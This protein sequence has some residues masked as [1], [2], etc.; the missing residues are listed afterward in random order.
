[1]ESMNLSRAIHHETLKPDKAE[2][3]IEAEVAYLQ[4][5]PA[6]ETEKLY[7]M[8]YDTEGK[9][10]MTN[11]K[12]ELKTISINNFRNMVSAPSFDTCGFATKAMQSSLKMA[13]FD[14]SAKVESIFY[15]EVK[16]LVREMYPGAGFIG[17]LE[18]QIRKRTPQFP[19]HTGEQYRNLLPTT[20]VH[21]DFTHDSAI[22]TGRAAFKEAADRHPHL[23][24]LNLW[25]S[26]QGPGD[27]W[28][29]ALC[30]VRTVDYEK[31]IVSQD[32]VF[33]D[34]LN[35]NSRVYYNKK[36]AWY[37]YPN[38]RDD[39][40]IVFQ[41]MDS[42]FPSGKGVPHSGFM[43]PFADQDAAPRVSIEIRVFVYFE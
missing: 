8:N 18:H 9:F 16:D 32:L 7:T 25:K 4:Y 38:L 29:L 12:N 42:R 17:V 43:N 2:N 5:D 13:E 22:K 15:T 28:P 3:A 10:P 27:D 19:Y 30:D 31:D 39:E 36:Q 11:T 37:Y 35:E 21:I 14:D 33:A 26:L 24:A 40:I 23:L 41:Q 1:M 20:L 34:R 6:H